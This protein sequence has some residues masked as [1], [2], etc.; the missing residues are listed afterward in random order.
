MF[1]AELLQLID[2]VVTYGY[3]VSNIS[4]TL[5]FHIQKKKGLFAPWLTRLAPQSVHAGKP[6]HQRP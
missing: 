2:C 3:D 5:Q 6:N 1:A 4:I